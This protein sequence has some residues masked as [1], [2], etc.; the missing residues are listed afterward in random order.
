MAS[1]AQITAS[2]ANAQLSTGP[3]SVEGKAASSRNALKLGIT[4]QSMIIPGED[5]AA[6]DRLNAEYH[7]RY[8]PVGP[9][10]CAVLKEAVR[11][12]WLRDRYYRIETDVINM[13]ADAHP[14]SKHAVAAA[15]DQDAKSGNALQR[16]FRRQQAADNDWRS[17]L[18][19]LE[20]LQERRRR[21]EIEEA[22]LARQ[23]AATPIRPVPSDSRVR[24]VEPPLRAPQPATSPAAPVNLAGLTALTPVSIADPSDRRL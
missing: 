13:R 8:Q 21:A 16:L 22:L 19:L 10:E 18:Q 17:A 23:S 6:L 2:R 5:P 14:E 7:D 20:Q 4:A 12:Q 15:F 1:P 9:V 11:A 24:S 3:R